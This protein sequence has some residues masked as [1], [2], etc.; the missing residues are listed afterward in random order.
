MTLPQ[1][2]EP[3]KALAVAKN[4]GER[5]V[6]TGGSHLNS[7][8][9]FKAVEMSVR[10]TQLNDAKANKK[11]RQ[12]LEKRDTEARNL[13]TKT[14]L[15][16][17]DCGKLLTWYG[18]DRKNLSAQQNKAKWSKFIDDNRPEPTFEKWTDA[19]EA[20]MKDL[21]STDFSLK[22]TALGRL[23]TA[24]RI[25]FEDHIAS[26]TQEER[27]EYLRELNPTVGT[28]VEL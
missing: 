9:A 21:E 24:R 22:D 4:H 28:A 8:D 5:F 17:T 10:K 20:A 16:D 11:K 19:D 1:S 25:E 18:V 23:K 6:V 14:S 27:A 2:D 7:D 26:M 3:V 12:M 13:L 15:N